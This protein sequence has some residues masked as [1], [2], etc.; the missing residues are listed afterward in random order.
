MVLCAVDDRLEQLRPR[1]RKG[2]QATVAVSVVLV[3]APWHLPQT[4]FLPSCGD[5]DA[6][7]FEC[8]G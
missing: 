6:A 2:H 8:N 1:H 3:H 7:M 4:N 5:L